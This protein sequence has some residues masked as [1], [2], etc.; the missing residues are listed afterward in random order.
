MCFFRAEDL[1]WGAGTKLQQIPW[2]RKGEEKPQ[3]N[4]INFSNITLKVVDEK[5]QKAAWVQQS[6][7]LNKENSLLCLS[8]NHSKNIPVL[9][10]MH[11]T[12]E[13]QLEKRAQYKKKPHMLRDIY[14]RKRFQIFTE[15]FLRAP[16]NA[17][18]CPHQHTVPAVGSLTWTVGS[19]KESRAEPHVWALSRSTMVAGAGPDVSR[20]QASVFRCSWN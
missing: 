13:G 4:I 20:S 10:S 6:P 8:E 19:G 3:V 18:A 11:K 14:W 12:R 16:N 9:L 5:F 15:H 7:N 2:R 1:T 17:Q